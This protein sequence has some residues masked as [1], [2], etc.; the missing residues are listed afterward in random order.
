[1]D[2]LFSY[3]QRILPKEI[4]EA[5]E[6]TEAKPWDEVVKVGFNRFSVGRQ[7]HQQHF[8]LSFFVANEGI[9]GHLI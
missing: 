9:F 6:W 1:M 4:L 7:F 5:A 3:L 8:C 2:M